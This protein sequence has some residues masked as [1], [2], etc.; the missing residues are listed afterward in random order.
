MRI[1]RNSLLGI[2]LGWAV[3]ISAILAIPLI[4][5]DAADRSPFFWHRVLWTSF[6][7]TMVWSIGGA[8][9]LR[10]TDRDVDTQR[11]AGVLPSLGLVVVGYAAASF[12]VMLLF[13]LVV[14]SHSPSKA[15]LVMQVLLAGAAGEQL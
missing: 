4:A 9:I 6:L 11:T 13:M 2:G 8:F 1:Q 12:V 10:S 7:A 5:I 14:D 3:T 15:P